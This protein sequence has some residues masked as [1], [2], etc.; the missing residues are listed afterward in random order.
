M[1]VNAKQTGDLIW[2]I[3]SEDGTP[4]YQVR[5]YS[6][7]LCYELFEWGQTKRKD[8]GELEWEWKALG[9]YPNNLP[10]ACDIMRDNLVMDNAGAVKDF[11][12]IKRAITQ[13]TN[14]IIKAIEAAQVMEDAKS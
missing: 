10:H 12:Q 1:K 7:H 8:T 4:L 3:N 14:A 5:P 2:T 13:S 6:N 9:V 11:T